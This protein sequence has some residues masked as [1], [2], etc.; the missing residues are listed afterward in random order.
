MKPYRLYRTWI[1]LTHVEAI[2][3]RPEGIMGRMWLAF[4]ND[5]LDVLLD[6]RI[7][8]D[9]AALKHVTTPEG[10]ERWKTFVEAWK[11][12]DTGEQQS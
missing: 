2:Q 3:E 1:D 6:E 8:W 9:S 4:R 11:N 5:P 7:I 12:R 10:M